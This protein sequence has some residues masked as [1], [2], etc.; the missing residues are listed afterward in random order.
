MKFLV[1]ENLP[2]GL[3]DWLRR[4]EH[5]ADHVIALG[6]SG[7]SDQEVAALAREA[8]SVVVTRDSDFDTI[9]E[10]QS[11]CVLR[12]TIGNAS[13]PVLLDWMEARWDAIIGALADEPV[14]RT[15]II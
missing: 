6:L 10:V 1:D 15:V 7:A 8:G 13:T 2:I 14:G 4:R 5:E 12:V 9:A 3:A 11:I